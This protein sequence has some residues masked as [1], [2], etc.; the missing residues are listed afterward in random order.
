MSTNDRNINVAVRRRIE[1]CLANDSLERLPAERALC[2]EFGCARETVRSVLSRMEGEGLIYRKQRSGWYPSPAPMTYHVNRLAGFNDR[3][4]LSGRIA[5]TVALSVTSIAA[6]TL[7]E[8]VL[9]PFVVDGP[10]E[11]LWRIDRVRSLDGMAVHSETVYLDGRLPGI[12]HWQ[13]DRSI[14][15]LLKREFGIRVASERLH[16]TAMS[17]PDEHCRRIG[18][19]LGTPGLFIVRHRFDESG[20]LIELDHEFWRAGSIELVLDESDLAKP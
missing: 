5:E 13:L 2:L 16:I 4:E 10:V 1:A 8:D 15:Q 6:S 14:T 7:T 12:N 9:C 11:W 20:R 18:A 3:A 19:S 17:L